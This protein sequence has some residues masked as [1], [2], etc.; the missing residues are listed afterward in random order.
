MRV[1]QDH[2]A[3][4]GK[5]GELYW[6]SC[7][8]FF[9]PNQDKYEEFEIRKSSSRGQLWLQGSVGT[10]KTSLT[11]LV[12]SHLIEASPQEE[13]GFYDCPKD[14]STGTPLAILQSL[15]SQMSWCSDGVNIEKV[16]TSLYKRE[17]RQRSL[18]CSLSISDCVGLLITLV[19]LHGPTTI[20][21]DGLDECEGPMRLLRELFKI[22]DSSEH[23]KLFLGS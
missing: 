13:L 16:V 14:T 9:N 18:E 8:W 12:I 6:G 23:V 2:S 1:G 21:I 5:L 10:G 7:Q 4:R 11:S 15:V 3:N 19:N 20:V 17:I 22:W